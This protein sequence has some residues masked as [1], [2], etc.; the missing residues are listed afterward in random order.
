MLELILVN[1]QIKFGGT[2]NYQKLL[3]ACCQE[4]LRKKKK[5]SK[6]CRKKQKDL[7]TAIQVSCFWHNIIPESPRFTWNITLN[8]TKYFAGKSIESFINDLFYLNVLQGDALENE[9]SRTLQCSLSHMEFIGELY[10][11]KLL[12]RLFLN[13]WMEELLVVN[14]TEENLESLC[15]LLSVA[16]KELQGDGD[17]VCSYCSNPSEQAH[18]VM[19]L[20]MCR[21]SS[22]NSSSLNIDIRTSVFV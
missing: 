16:G 1:D 6:Y 8:G 14:P 17:K 12:P 18:S 22:C 10:K 9:K 15:K 19:P 20:W 3:L 2:T 11:R 5:L 13:S 4:K 7:D 21:I